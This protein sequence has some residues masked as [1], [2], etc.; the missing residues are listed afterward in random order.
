MYVARLKTSEMHVAEDVRALMAGGRASEVFF[1]RELGAGC[2]DV[3]CC[4]VTRV[5]SFSACVRPACL[6]ELLTLRWRM[7]TRTARVKLGW[8]SV[9]GQSF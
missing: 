5:R 2:K 1:C 4:R 6:L 8:R 9:G 7:T 3:S